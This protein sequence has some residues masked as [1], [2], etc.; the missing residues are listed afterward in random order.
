[1]GKKDK[2]SKK[3]K[4]DKQ[5]DVVW[6]RYKGG[7]SYLPINGGWLVESGNGLTFIPDPEH[8]MPPKAI[9]LD[10]TDAFELPADGE[11]WG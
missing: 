4:K 9:E 8:L 1:M 10:D 3:D 11:G 6:F 7:Y 2:K 5:S